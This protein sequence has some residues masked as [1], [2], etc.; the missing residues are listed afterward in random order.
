MRKYTIPQSMSVE[1]LLGDHPSPP[2]RTSLGSTS[3]TTDANGA[4]VSELRYKL[5]PLR[6]TSGVL[7]KGEL[8]Y[9]WT[10]APA[11]TPAYELLNY[12]FTGQYSDSYINLLW[13]NS[14]HYDPALGRF[15][16]PDSIVPTFVQGVQ[17]YDRFAYVNNSPIMYID[18]T[19]HFSEEQISS[20]LKQ[21]YG[22]NWESYLK[23]W[24]SDELFWEMLLAAQYGDELFA[25]ESDLGSGI[26]IENG[27]TFGFVGESELYEYQGSGPYI[28][29][30][31]TQEG[32]KL[33][34]ISFSDYYNGDRRIPFTGILGASD[35][36]IRQPIYDYSTGVPLYTGQDNVI[37]YGTNPDPELGGGSGVPF[38]I[39][40]GIARLNSVRNT[41]F[42][43]MIFPVAVL[44]YLNTG[45]FGQEKVLGVMTADQTRSYYGWSDYKQTSYHKY[46][47]SINHGR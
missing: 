32:H 19:G 38:I 47:F 10:S 24:K 35:T 34:D 11:T 22:K 14:R 9:T 44:G 2:L 40:G 15:I 23:A 30:Y 26:F 43:K 16:S 45:P 25:P 37:Y 42:G 20:F 5:C 29:E 41:L 4:K 27:S 33:R 31:K 21:K 6:Y 13:Y 39:T 28:L 18:P 17:A 12:T 8:R 1:Y 46:L 3:L 36:V 7:R